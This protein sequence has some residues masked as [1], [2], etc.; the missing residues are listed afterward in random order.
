MTDTSTHD[1]PPTVALSDTIQSL[2]IGPRLSQIEALSLR[3]YLAN[4]HDVHLYVYDEVTDVP[5]GVVLKDASQILH[6]SLIF[7]GEGT[8]ALFADWFRQELLYQV[9]GYWT[10]L[11]MV[12]LKPLRFSDPIVVG[13]QDSRTVCNALMRFP[14]HHPVTRQLADLSREPNTRLSFDNAREVRR[15]WV[16]KYLQGN[17]RWNVEWGEVSGPSGLTRMLKHHGLLKV[18]KPYYF[19]YPLHFA[20][21]ACSYDDTFKESLA[22]F[23][24]SYCVHLWNEK[25]AKGGMTKD[26]TFPASSLIG[27]LLARYR[28]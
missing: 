25:L 27:Q 9:G 4:G 19:F 8:R 14:R 24:Q 11:D 28:G 7:P 6:P 3:S 21:A 26:G 22:A 5:T 18:A 17:R 10:D 20:L 1:G 15:K 23:D 12:C 16:R 2:W 13:R